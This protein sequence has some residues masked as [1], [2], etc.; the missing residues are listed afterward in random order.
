M[1]N[2]P[3]IH[4]VRKIRDANA[5]K[6]RFDAESMGQEFIAQQRKSEREVINLWEIAKKSGKTP[7]AKAS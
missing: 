3:L 4:E 5:K 7:K 6:H 2:D 1:I